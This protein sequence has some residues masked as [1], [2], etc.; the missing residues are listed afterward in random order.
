ME[1]LYMAILNKPN[2]DGF[3]TRLFLY[4]GKDLLGGEEEWFYLNLLDQSACL[5]KVIKFD[6]LFDPMQQSA[7]LRTSVRSLLIRCARC[8]RFKVHSVQGEI[9]WAHMP[10][11]DWIHQASVTVH[12][13]CP[14][15]IDAFRK[16]LILDSVGKI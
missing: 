12:T 6:E 5:E 16:E 4:P 13:A 1:V 2:F 10:E 9:A 15:C 8:T 7:L 3:Y 14:E 11:V